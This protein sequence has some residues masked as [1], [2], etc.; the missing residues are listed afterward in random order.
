MADV[1][2]RPASPR[3][4]PRSPTRSMRATVGQRRRRQRDRR[5]AHHGQPRDEDL[6]PCVEHRRPPPPRQAAARQSVRADGP[7]FIRPRDADRDLCGI[8]GVPC[9]GGRD[10]PAIAGNRRAD[11]MGM[12][13]TRG[14]HLRD[15][16]RCAL[17]AE[18]APRHGRASSTRRPR[19]KTGCRCSMDGAPLYPD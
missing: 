7:A 17:P 6:P 11:R 12:A 18:G 16:R 5:A 2:A 13:A 10:G 15:L 14:R 3:S 4:P 9:Q 1:L 19:R 8:A